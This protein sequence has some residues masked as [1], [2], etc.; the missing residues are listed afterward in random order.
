MFRHGISTDKFLGISCESESERTLLIQKFRDAG[1]TE[2]NGIDI[3]DFIQVTKSVQEDCARGI[4]GL[5]YY[6]K[7][8]P[9]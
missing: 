5:S 3:D 8:N 9:F 4:Q 2:Y 7:D 1:I 6:D